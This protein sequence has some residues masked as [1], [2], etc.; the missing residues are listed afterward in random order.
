MKNKKENIYTIMPIKDKFKEHSKHHSK[1]HITA[2]KKMMKA[3]LTFSKS[4]KLTTQ[5][6]GN[7][8]KK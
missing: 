6:I 4:H 1:K 2:M 7:G 8:K 5:L 3:G